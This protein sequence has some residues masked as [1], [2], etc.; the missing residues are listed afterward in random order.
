MA[1]CHDLFLDFLEAIRLGPT[2]RESLRTSR[3]ANRERIRKYFKDE[4]KREVPLFHSQGSFPMHT[5][6]TPERGDFDLDDGVY[7][8]GLGTDPDKWP[9]TSTVH[10]W[11]VKATEGYTSEPPQDKNRCVRARYAAGYHIDLPIYAMNADGKPLIFDKSADKP[12]ESD[13][14][15]FTEWFQKHVKERGAQLRRVT[16][17]LKAYRDHQ[18]GGA[19]AA[20]GLG[21][22]VL[23]VNNFVSH[24]RDDVAFAETVKAVYVHMK[25]NKTI[26]KPTFP[27]EDLTSW[28]DET[29]RANFMSK[30][31]SLRDRSVDA[32]EEEGKE[33]ASKIWSR[34]V[35]GSRFPIYEPEEE[36][37]KKSASAAPLRTSAPAI[38]GSDGRSA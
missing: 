14:R 22:T 4:L 34:R 29:K 18:G 13:P 12:Y 19:A 31:E 11:V 27:Y 36:A 23:A 7:L 30:L 28:W 32:V 1:D 24:E 16:R 5:I 37:A 20:S 10:G 17:Y 33:V 9:A 8:Q 25:Y 26:R 6:I 15:A 38:L 35:F 2:K 21:Y 3:D